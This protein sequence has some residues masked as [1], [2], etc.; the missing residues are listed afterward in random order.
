[1]GDADADDEDGVR[2]SA[3][4]GGRFGSIVE[5]SG[6]G[7]CILGLEDSEGPVPPEVI[8]DP[9]D[10]AELCRD[11]AKLK[12]MRIANQIPN[13]RLVKL[14]TLLLLNIRDGVGVV[15]T[16]RPVSCF[17]ALLTILILILLKLSKLGGNYALTYLLSFSV[18]CGMLERASLVLVS[19]NLLIITLFLS[20][21]EE[22]DEHESKRW[23]E[24]AM[25]RVM[26][27]VHSGLIGIHLMTS[28]DMPRE[29]Y[30]EDVIERTV[31][32]VRFQLV[33]CIYPEYDPAYRG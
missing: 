10:L 32:T 20:Q 27:S 15:A 23:R 5:A 26:R 7:S 22:A 18:I 14:L 29:V 28:N 17:P 1:D 25:E 11:A 16:L 19:S 4:N 2:I 24:L 6:N 21:E 33:N 9:N 12:A 8:L 31:Q 30:V 13:D 3:V